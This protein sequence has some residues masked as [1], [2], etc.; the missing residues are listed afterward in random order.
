MSQK[1][2]MW[3]PSHNAPRHLGTKPAPKHGLW[4][5][6]TFIVHNRW[7]RQSWHIRLELGP[8]T[9]VQKSKRLFYEYSTNV[10]TK[11]HTPCPPISVNGNV[12]C[13]QRV[14]TPTYTRVTPVVF[15][16]VY[17]SRTKTPTRFV[18]WSCPECC[19]HGLSK[20]TSRLALDRITSNSTPLYCSITHVAKDRQ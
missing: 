8:T 3:P 1:C 18:G 20:C 10:K 5:R 2:A 17:T 6:T 7:T 14:N 16:W 11:N 9:A 13:P 19:Q 12:K 15:S 4:P